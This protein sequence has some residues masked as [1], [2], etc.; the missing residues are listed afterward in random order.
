MPKEPKFF[1]LFDQQVANVVSATALFKELAE[2]GR[3]D[4]EG[5]RKMD[6][7]EHEGDTLAHETIDTLNRTFITPF[8]REDI[9][10]LTCE[11]DDVA[12]MIHA[13]TTRSR[14]Y[15]IEGRDEFLVQ[16]AETMHQ[17]SQALAKAV[18]S[19][20]EIK[21]PRRILDWCIEVNRLENVGDQL[22]E[23]AIGKLF[24]STQ[25]ALAVIKKKE[26]YE[27]AETVL[28]KCEHVANTVES[29]LV[30]QG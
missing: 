27:G 7:I 28:D 3:F 16:F 6:D 25:D 22:R 12:D 24:E 10:S 20:R 21:R 19:L 17:S 8:D 2:T 1:D 30:K 4:D 18:N 11:L 23:A 29:I 15:K 9:H 5:V 26:I 14:L 13:I